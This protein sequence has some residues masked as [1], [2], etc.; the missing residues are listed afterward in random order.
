V[1]V[2]GNDVLALVSATAE[3]AARARRGEG[4]TLIE[5]RTYRRGPHSSSD[6]PSVYR[7]PSEPREWEAHDPI[8]RFRR[9]LTDRKLWTEVDEKRFLE[10]LEATFLGLLAEVEKLPPPDH[11]TIFGDVYAEQPWNLREQAAELEAELRRRG[12]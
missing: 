9:Y 3:A 1:L 12:P 7:D 6:D 4:P 2:D 11:D 10:G 8:V 5:A